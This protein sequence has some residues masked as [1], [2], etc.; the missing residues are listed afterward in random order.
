[1][2][3]DNKGV[4]LPSE[5]LVLFMDILGFRNLIAR[6]SKEPDLYSHVR[7]ALKTMQRV[8]RDNYKKGMAGK[9][10]PGEDSQLVPHMI[11]FSDCIV[12]SYPLHFPALCASL[13]I[14]NAQELA[15]QLLYEGVLTRG[16]IACGWTYH[17][18]SV[19][20]GAGVIAA[21]ELE[22]QV[23]DVPR[24]V[25]ADEV[26]SF[27]TNEQF[28][29]RQ[30]L[31]KDS[32]GCWIIKPFS[33]LRGVLLP[34]QIR[35]DEKFRDK[36][37]QAFTWT[38]AYILQQLDQIKGKGPNLLAKYRWLANQF[39]IAAKEAFQDMNISVETIRI[40]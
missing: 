31:E 2:T 35:D 15:T 5:R 19:L 8:V 11:Q 38:R 18:E 9:L 1:M 30:D 13:I 40:P 12:I 3:V 22:S 23:A 37:I 28:Y 6:M 25:L 39:N 36:L 27:L 24:I 14:L 17:D 7:D 26:V 34:Q 21:Y 20:L 29:I 33:G 4:S 10:F 16:G 32:D